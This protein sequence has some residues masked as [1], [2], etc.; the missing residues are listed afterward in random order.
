MFWV[1]TS[2]ESDEHQIET[3]GV[4]CTVLETKKLC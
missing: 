4:I 3:K 1:D 2:T